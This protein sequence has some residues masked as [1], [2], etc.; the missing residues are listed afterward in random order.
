MAKHK[1]SFTIGEISNMLGMSPEQVDYCEQQGLVS[2]QR[3]PRTGYRLYSYADIHTLTIVHD[4]RRVGFSFSQIRDYLDNMN[5]VKSIRL[6]NDH[7]KAIDDKLFDL[8]RQRDKISTRLGCYALGMSSAENE[9]VIPITYGD[10]SAL[11][12]SDQAV[13]SDKIDWARLEFM[14][15]RSI[16]ID[17]YSVILCYTIDANSHVE[18]DSFSIKDVFLFAPKNPPYVGNR[19]IPAGT[20]LTVTF[21]GTPQR[22]PHILERIRDYAHKNDYV[23]CGDPMVFCVADAYESLE[24]SEHVTRLEVPTKPKKGSRLRDDRPLPP[25]YNPKIF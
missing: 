9:K 10:R 3:H 15:S 6:L 24:E 13:A 23:I 18:E 7:V 22:S 14:K 16:D 21:R 12:I 1:E 4:L 5:L 25:P 8:I 17:I 11:V 20:Y 19:T 2:P